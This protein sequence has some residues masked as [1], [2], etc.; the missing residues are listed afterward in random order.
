MF[1]TPLLEFYRTCAPVDSEE[2]IDY[3]KAMA[4]AANYAW[5]NRQ[6]IVHWVRESFEKVFK[7]D[8]EDMNMGLDV[9]EF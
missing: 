5:T 4:A 2:A 7:Q 8:A 9:T 6:M 1:Y 3:F